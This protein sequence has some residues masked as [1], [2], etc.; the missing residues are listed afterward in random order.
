MKRRTSPAAPSLKTVRRFSHFTPFKPRP[1]AGAF[2]F[3]IT[4]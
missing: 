1:G 4:S 3:E 2:L